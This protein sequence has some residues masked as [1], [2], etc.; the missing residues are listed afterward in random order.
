MLS[1]YQSTPDSTAIDCW[2]FATIGENTEGSLIITYKNGSQYSY[3]N[4]PSAVAVD[5]I[6]QVSVGRFV[7]SVIKP[8]YEFRKIEEYASL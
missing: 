2:S 6:T 4:V 8:N 5:M 7:A 3:W 1:I